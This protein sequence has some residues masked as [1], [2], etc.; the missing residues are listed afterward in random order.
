MSRAR[1]GR[2]G[3]RANNPPEADEAQQAP[4]PPPMAII[5]SPWEGEIDLNTKHGKSLWDEGI[6]PIETKFTGQG[7]DLVRFL[8][9]ISNQVSKCRWMNV[10]TI[11]G[12][13]LLTR[14]GEIT[15][16]D[17]IQARAARRAAVVTTLAEARPQI[18]ALMM[19]HFIYNSL[20]PAAQKKMNTRLGEIDQDGPL[21]LKT[22]LDDT[23]VA[24]TAS[25]FTIKE[26]FYDLNLKKYKWNVLSLNQDVRE[27][28][29]D[30]MAAGH[31][32]DETDLIITL[33]RAYA[34][35]T[36]EEFK[37]SILFWKN[38]WTS[39]AFTT[40]EELMM[41]ADAKYVELKSM[42]TWGKRSDKD[43]QIIALTAKI[44]ELTKGGPSKQGNSKSES[45][46]KNQVP[47]WK[48]DKSLSKGA[49]YERNGKTYHWCTGPGHQGKA[50]W[51][52][53]TPGTCTAQRGGSQPSSN[54][55]S[56]AN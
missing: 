8:A 4:P 49:T 14:Y 51:V 48:Y 18:N 11:G 1:A 46:K 39:Q 29:V 28:K 2:G 44:N 22:V 3:G 26:Q 50:M 21:L 20:G 34:T 9:L 23:F 6:K 56:N 40:A 47:K 43:E 31:A 54:N 16:E 7:K 10:T 13:N 32:T 45:E 15:R 30:L 41:R 35:A 5:L 36:N 19:F 17:V 25:T 55:H 37:N 24:S 33:F 27:K 42:G 53:H 52:V 12:M 38:E